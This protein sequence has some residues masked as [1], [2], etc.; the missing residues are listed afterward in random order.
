MQELAF[1]PFPEETEWVYWHHKEAFQLAEDTYARWVLFAV[2][3]GGFRYRILDEEG[4]AAAGDVVVCPPGVRFEREVVQP[5]S[6]A[7]ISFTLR[8]DD[9]SSLPQGRVNTGDTARLLHNLAQLKPS[10]P[11][12][13][14][15]WHPYGAHYAA[16]IWLQC[17]QT[18]GRRRQAPA[19]P[20]DAAMEAAASWLRSHV[21]AK[22]ALSEAAAL[23]G[24]TPVQF[25]RRFQ[26]AFG[27]PPQ[28]FMLS[29]RMAEARKLL[30]STDWTLDRIALSCG[31]ENGFSLSRSF[32]R[33]TGIRPSSYRGLHRL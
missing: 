20:A 31:Y 7:F 24:L 11:H 30:V 12:D 26:R 23:C 17:L 33:L 10:H 27:M 9:L 29:L 32:V 16:D 3:S 18:F 22:A 14:S 13:S 5:L 21:E 15:A 4:T 25:T 28:Q 19:E 8:A 1:P 6:F 2:E